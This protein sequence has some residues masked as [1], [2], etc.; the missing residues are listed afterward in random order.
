MNKRKQEQL[1]AAGWK[2]GTAAEFLELTPEEEALVEIRYRLSQALRQRR[3]SRKMSQAELARRLG[4]S[5]SRIA[6]MEAADK[7][8]SIDLLL[9]GLL[10]LGAT[11]QDVARAFV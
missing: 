4:S 10:A 1:A 7:S 5:Q 3:L 9:K 8:V 6:K 2:V 11:S